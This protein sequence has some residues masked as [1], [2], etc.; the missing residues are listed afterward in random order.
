MGKDNKNKTKQLDESMIKTLNIT[1]IFTSP[2]NNEVITHK[3]VING[4]SQTKMCN[5]PFGWESKTIIELDYNGTL[6]KKDLTIFY[7]V[8]RCT[9]KYESIYNLESNK[10]EFTGPIIGCDPNKKNKNPNKVSKGMDFKTRT[11]LILE[12]KSEFTYT[13]KFK[14]LKPEKCYDILS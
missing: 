6:I 10:A 12:D 11:T 9:S 1:C 5:K 7:V 8:F 13:I 14:I 2:S 4:V 3:E